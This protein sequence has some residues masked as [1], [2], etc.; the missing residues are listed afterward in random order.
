MPMVLEI[1]QRLQDAAIA[2]MGVDL[3]GGTF[4]AL[5]DN[6][7]ALFEQPGFEPE[8]VMGGLAHVVL[9]LQVLI[10]NTSYT[11]AE[12]KARAV[13]Q[14]LDRFKGVLSGVQYYSILARSYP[15]HLGV[16]ENKRHRWTC[17]YTVRKDL[18]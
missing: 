2:T 13:Y 4:P 3:W 16:D 18:S 5:P 15:F 1:G 14:N 10:R 11:N 12:T 6:L 7:I 17:N 9:N 8:R